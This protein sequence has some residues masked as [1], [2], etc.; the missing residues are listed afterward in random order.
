MDDF[1]TRPRQVHDIRRI[2]LAVDGSEESRQA[3]AHVRGMDIPS[4]EIRIVSIVANLR[5]LSFMGA[6]IENILNE[7][8]DELLRDADAS[9]KYARRAFEGSGKR[10]TAERIDLPSFDDDI[11]GALATLVDE[12]ET[13]LLVVGTRQHHGL[14]RWLEGSVSE[15]V[16]RR[17]HCSILMVPG[18]HAISSP[19]PRRILFA[20]DGSAA[21]IDALRL[22][23]QLAGPDTRLRAIYV[24]DKEVRFA[25]LLP[26]HLLE[27]AFVKEGNATLAEA[28]G[29][30]LAVANPAD[31]ALIAVDS[32]RDD[33]AHA[34]LRD[35]AQWQADLLVVGAHGHRGASRWLTGSVANRV[36]QIVPIPLFLGRA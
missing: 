34:I 7:A 14:Q 21:A 24:V 4:A 29:I 5:T 8:R 35:A 36:A 17:S 26:I 23:V 2:L 28:A 3:V 20:L 9:L 33:V 1:M 27:D 6:N 25:D 31:T 19:W 32:P 12:W 22:G 18:G 16:S 11:G 15:A 10:F 13:D 30:L